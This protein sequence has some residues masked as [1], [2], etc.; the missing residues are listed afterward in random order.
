MKFD[1]S[2]YERKAVYTLEQV[3]PFVI[4]VGLSDIKPFKNFDGDPIKMTSD[5]YKL[6]ASKGVQCVGCNL[7]GTYFAKERNKSPVE[8][9]PEKIKTRYHLNLYGI[10]DAGNEIMLTKDHIFPSSAGGLDELKNLQTM[11]QACNHRKSGV[12][13]FT[14]EEALAKGLVAKKHL[15]KS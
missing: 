10:D 14:F 11:C 12:L 13:P 4:F 7:T 2:H 3:L 15:G 9:D 6:F 8:K 1:Y 5:R